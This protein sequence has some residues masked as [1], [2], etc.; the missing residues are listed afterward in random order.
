[1]I[2]VGIVALIFSGG[3][4]MGSGACIAWISF[5]WCGGIYSLEGYLGMLLFLFGACLWWWAIVSVPIKIVAG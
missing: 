1:M 4:A 5:G 3:V 2:W